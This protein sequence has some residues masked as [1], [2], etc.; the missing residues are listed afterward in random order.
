VI[1]TGGLYGGG[2]GGQGDFSTT[3]V[4]AHGAVRIIWPGI[5][6]SFPSTNVGPS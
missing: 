4:P 3:N 5:V 6:R 2:K 1:D